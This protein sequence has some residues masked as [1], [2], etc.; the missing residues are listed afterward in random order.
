[1][2]SV[3]V[4][5]GTV[6]HMKDAVCILNHK[7]IISSY[8]TAEALYFRFSVSS[9][10]SLSLGFS[11]EKTTPNIRQQRC[12]QVCSLGSCLEILR[13]ITFLFNF[14]W[15]SP[16]LMSSFETFPSLL[17]LLMIAKFNLNTS[18]QRTAVPR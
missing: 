6:R 1:M 12:R 9:T 14:I 17:Q 8:Y 11:R 13:S 10:S 5:V 7:A 4:N 16:I 2:L 3:I 18:L 15:T